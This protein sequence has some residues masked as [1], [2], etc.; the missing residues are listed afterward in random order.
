[1]KRFATA[2]VAAVTAISLSTTAAVAQSSDDDNTGDVSP[3]HEQSAEL[4]GS[5]VENSS[6]DVQQSSGETWLDIFGSS[7]ENDADQEW[8]TGSSADLI[9]A[10]LLAIGGAAAV[11]NG[12]VPGLQLPNF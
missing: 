12:A 6:E 7:Y 2:A 8:A 5:T 9:I 4:V 3:G 11:M 1:M 10:A